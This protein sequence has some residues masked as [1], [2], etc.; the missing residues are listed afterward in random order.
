MDKSSASSPLLGLVSPD[1]ELRFPIGFGLAYYLIGAVLLDFN[2]HKLH[3]RASRDVQEII[4]GDDK[5]SYAIKKRSHRRTLLY[6]RTLRRYVFLHTWSLVFAA[7]LLWLFSETHESVI[8]FLSYVLS[9][10]GKFL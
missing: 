4:E 10:T 8:L 2:A 9:Y 1:S 5:L 3:E 7:T 6:W